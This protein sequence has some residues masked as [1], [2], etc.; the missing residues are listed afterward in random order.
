MG[1]EIDRTQLQR[2][3]GRA[4]TLL[5]QSQQATATVFGGFFAV[6]RDYGINV[7]GDVA[8]AFRTLTSLDGTLQALAPGY[9]LFA[10]ARQ[11]LPEIVTTL[12]DPQRLSK[13]TEAVTLTTAVISRRA[14]ARLEQLSDQLAR[15]ELTVRTRSFSHA[16][17][18]AW[19]RRM[20][21][22]VISAVFAAVAI[23]LA[24]IFLLAPGG[25]PIT[26]VLSAWHLVA[27]VLGF[28]G[29]VLALRLVVRLF[30]RDRRDG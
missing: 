4:I 22:D 7:P 1:D 20:L 18:Q 5:V 26:P 19:L 9:G 30:T 10:G 28:L 13:L 29:L 27:A 23:A 21:D 25:P 24:A 2:D 3:L 16:A 6:L 15:G 12:A 11:A 14:P 8:G 17:D